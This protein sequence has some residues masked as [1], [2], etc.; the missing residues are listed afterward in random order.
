MGTR[1]VA[2]GGKSGGEADVWTRVCTAVLGTSRLICSLCINDAFGRS[3]FGHFVLQTPFKE[4][5]KKKLEKERTDLQL[6]FRIACR[7]QR[8]AN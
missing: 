3:S 2:R 6:G 1:P 8:R 5:I 7:G 4:G